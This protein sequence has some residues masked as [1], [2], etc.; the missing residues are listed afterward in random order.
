MAGLWS[1][2]IEALR[3]GLEQMTMMSCDPE[4]ALVTNKTELLPSDWTHTAKIRHT[5]FPAIVIPSPW[6][7]SVIDLQHS[8]QTRDH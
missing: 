5:A 2:L 1:T 3:A 7:S 6:P 8:D 4:T